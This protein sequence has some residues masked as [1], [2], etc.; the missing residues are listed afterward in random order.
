MSRSRRNYILLAVFFAIF[1]GLGLLGRW[2]QGA[3]DPTRDHSSLRTNP[4][5]TKAYRQLLE[6]CGVRTKTWD[7][8]LDKLTD[9][10]K[11]LMVLAPQR[12]LSED[13]QEG[14][15]DWVRDGGR[16]V[17]ALYGREIVH[18]A[19][20]GGSCRVEGGPDI[21]LLLARFGLLLDARGASDAQ[22]RVG[23]TSAL[24]ADVRHAIIPSPYRLVRAEGNKELRA[25]LVEQG[26]DEETAAELPS[27]A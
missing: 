12:S 25:A 1:V 23:E 21:R 27:P 16:L 8:P 14:L 24:T 20:E 15:L 22:A 9:R 7:K 26:V 10:V 11:L 18:P 4:W 17:L 5:G 6:R 2:G 3:F 19:C 13:E